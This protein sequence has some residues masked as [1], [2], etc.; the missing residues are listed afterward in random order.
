MSSAP[1]PADTPRPA[2]LPTEV[3]ADNPRMPVDGGLAALGLV[4]LAAA[5]VGAVL[6]IGLFVTAVTFG[7]GGM[8]GGILP[9]LLLFAASLV[10]T[11]YHIGAARAAAKRR[12]D[13][14]DAA[15]RYVFVSVIHTVLTLGLTVFVWTRG[16]PL[17]AIL[18]TLLVLV[19]Y[20]M[21]WP[22]VFQVLVKRRLVKRIFSTMETFDVEVV[23]GDRGVGSAGV[24]MAVF[25]ALFLAIDLAMLALL[26]T[27]G[28]IGG[29]GIAWLVTLSL[30]VVR[31]AAPLRWGLSALRGRMDFAAFRKMTDVY[32]FVSA[33]TVIAALVAMFLTPELRLAFSRAPFNIIFF[34]VA[35]A[36]ALLAWPASLRAYAADAVPFWDAERDAERAFRPAVDRGLT[37]LGYLHL[38]FSVFGVTA[39]VA[40]A[41]GG[42]MG[43]LVPG[44]VSGGTE[45]DMLLGLVGVGAQLWVALELIGMTARYQLA[46]AIYAVVALGLTLLELFV[47]GDLFGA[48]EG[49]AGA[50]PTIMIITGAVTSLVMPT[51][52]FVLSRGKPP[53]T[54]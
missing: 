23:P 24:L 46:A 20:L 41:I 3:V 38:W 18:P 5:S 51:M 30:F 6:A 2:A 12:S 48:L 52:T 36:T 32:L 8:R 9:M 53:L 31:G 28:V 21:G 42:G 54:M 10:R 17:A 40:G 27:S 43:G 16:I 49:A 50:M 39:W 34:A 11:G 45:L 35:I 13:V 29:A 7:F 19:L 37:A 26:L 47:L 44:V 25:S 33:A 14:G 4:G 1:S 22:I 15:R